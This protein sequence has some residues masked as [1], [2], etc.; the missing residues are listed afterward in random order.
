LAGAGLGSRRAIE[1][2]IRDGRVTVN[3]RV[4]QLGDRAGEA[5]DIRLDG[6]KLQLGGQGAAAPD[7]V[8]IYHKP[9]G[10]VT[11]RS[12]PQGR[13]TVFERL[14]PPP[15]GRWIV[16]GRLDVKTSG[17]LLF[18]TDGDLAHRLMHPSSEIER[19]YLVRVRGR[20]QP[21][22]IRKLLEGVEL[23]DGLARFDR[24]TQ[25]G[26]AEDGP[27]Q[28][29]GLGMGPR[30]SLGLSQGANPG[31]NLGTSQ[32]VNQGV[33]RG[34]SWSTKRSGAD[35]GVGRGASLNA[36][37]GAD[38]SATRNAGRGA[39]QTASQRGRFVE[40]RWV[41]RGAD[42]SGGQGIGQSVDQGT[43]QGVGQGINTTFRVVLH[44]GRNREV[45]RL[46][47]AV[48]LDV[49]RLLRVRYGPIELP[50]DLRPGAARLMEAAQIARLAA[51]AERKEGVGSGAAGKPRGI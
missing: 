13:P 2:W 28:R 42:Q 46:W 47:Q 40:S 38:D 6:R 12:D 48:G 22:I 7:A 14:P 44:E 23:E 33:H 11:T 25:E 10:E 9:L 32:S 8:L 4:A 21:G 5:D 50:R 36:N 16:V 30:A 3:G 29:L 51:A 39:D 34:V 17:L 37:R 49:S 27:A 43:D 35:P 20:P 41:D 45:R 26:A 15:Q 31:V 19:E 1:V 24:V 18:T